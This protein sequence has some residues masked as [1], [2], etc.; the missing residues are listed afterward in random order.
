MK[1]SIDNVNGSDDISRQAKIPNQ[2][3]ESDTA[4]SY[5]DEGQHAENAEVSQTALATS[6][7]QQESILTAEQ[8]ESLKGFDKEGVGIVLEKIAVDA[9]E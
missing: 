9:S 6:F 8:I 4:S 2:Q 7:A 1:R 3:P 5:R